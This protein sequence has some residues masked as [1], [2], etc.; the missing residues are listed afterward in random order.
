MAEEPGIWDRIKGAATAATAGFTSPAS[1]PQSDK[2]SAELFKDI[3]EEERKQKEKLV[4]QAYLMLNWKKFTDL[5][6]K[7]VTPDRSL[8][9]F[10]MID[11][12]QPA[13]LNNLLFAN[14]P[15]FDILLNSTSLQLSYLIPKIRLFKEYKLGDKVKLIEFPFEDY[16]SEEDLG[17]MLTNRS[18]RGSGVGLKSLSWTSLG[19]NNANKYSFSAELELFFQNIEDV[20]R[21]RRID[22]VGSQ[23]VLTKYSDLILQQKK[24]ITSDDG[25]SVYNPDYFKI[26]AMVGWQVPK[27]KPEFMN[28]EFLDEIKASNLSLYMGLA[29]HSIDIAENGNVTIK[30]TYISY[31]EAVMDNPK[32]SNVLYIEEDQALKQKK[33]QLDALEATILEEKNETEIQKKQREALTKEIEELEVKDKLKIYSRIL[34]NLYSNNILRYTKI[35]N[36][37]LDNVLR[38]M[39]TTPDK[40][41]SEQQINE[42]RNIIKKT[43]EANEKVS[44]L[45]GVGKPLANFEETAE[46]KVQKDISDAVNSAITEANQKIQKFVPNVSNSEKIVVYFYLGD[47]L[48]EILKGMFNPDSQRGSYNFLTKDVKVMLG[49]VTFYDYGE[50]VDSGFVVK[51]PALKS[52]E[53]ETYTKIYTGK[54]EAI[55]IADIPIALSVF[56]TWFNTNIVDKGIVNMTFKEFVEQIVSDLAIRIMSTE[57]Y[58]FAPRQKTRL[59]YKALSLPK[60]KE[61]F[62]PSK[63]SNCFRFQ[64]NDLIGQD[65]NKIFRD[66]KNEPVEEEET[67]NF[68]FIYGFSENAWDLK[69]DY[70]QDIKKGIRHIYYGAETGLVKNIKFNRQDNPLI[71]SHNIKLASGGGGNDSKL[72]KEVYNA[73]VDMFGNTIFDVGQTIYI[74]PSFFGSAKVASRIKF[75][76]ELNIGGYFSINKITNSISEGKF[77]TSLDL[78]W[79]ALGDGKINIGDRQPELADNTK[80]VG[81]K[82]EIMPI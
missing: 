64:V 46:V 11:H 60:N 52:G 62:P 66:T 27:Q 67:E 36:E 39:V 53:K 72:L 48:Q 30:I 34:N 28:Q 37:E 1:A 19:T 71:R 40:L 32:I 63:N 42:Q 15:K 78:K 61:R 75:A 81:T 3:D 49:P 59:V 4:D 45:S 73:T 10:A 68:V 54:R 5:S 21:V 69:S 76:K 74:E 31:I 26:K 17:S 57:T 41:S 8:D 14:K 16:T 38:Y 6:K 58:A 47:L 18:G 7:D 35:N 44:E 77:N 22:T 20:F 23:E 79:T 12:D 51:T 29:S 2:T 56:T 24:Y 13:E 43:K 9:Q 50:L 25:P 55:N 65:Q 82:V 80:N 33:E 70:E